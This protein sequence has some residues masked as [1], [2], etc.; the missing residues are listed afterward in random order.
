MKELLTEVFAVMRGNRMRLLLT[1]FSIGWGLFILIVMLGSGNGVVR[2]V[3]ASF[4]PDTLCTLHMTPA[5]TSQ[6]WHGHNP[7]R[8]L[9]FHIED[10]EAIAKAFPYE[11]RSVRMQNQSPPI[12]IVSGTR[13]IKSAVRGCQIG[14]CPFEY[15]EITQGRDFTEIDMQRHSNV[16]LIGRQT[17][18]ILFGKDT[19]PSGS[20]I[21]ANG[22]SFKIVG[23]YDSPYGYGSGHIVYVPFITCRDLFVPDGSVSEIIVV[24]N[25]VNN[26]RQLKEFKDKIYRF[27][28]GRL[29][30]NPDDRIAIACATY[31]DLYFQL[32]SVLGMLQLFIWIVG[33][34]TL[35]SGIVGVSN[36][37]IIGI[38]ERI[39][40]FGVRIAM[41]A[42][43]LSIIRLVL[44]ESVI[45]TL[46]FGYIGMM[47]GIGLTQAMNWILTEVGGV[48]YFENPTVDFSIMVTALVIMVVSGLLAGIFPALQAVRLKL[49]DSLN[50]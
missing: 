45:V 21:F 27:L 36:M 39:R 4:G 13:K 22:I 46:I 34:A 5:K 28:A 2:G 1:G 38:R 17:A 10:A 50:S 19:D 23:V 6:A 47:A 31:S 30:F 35:I 9:V 48:T 26:E 33:L 15:T 25:D 3:T 41:G 12:D 7:Q 37:M 43:D 40:E 11:V 32:K 42:S 8:E 24:A 18:D 20:E 16:C 44:L 14:Y 49:V 29:D